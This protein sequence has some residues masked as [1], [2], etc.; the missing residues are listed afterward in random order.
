[1]GDIGISSMGLYSLF[2]SFQQLSSISFILLL[3]LEKYKSTPLSP[4]LRHMRLSSFLVLCAL[5]F[6]GAEVH[7]LTDDTFDSFIAKVPYLWA[8]FLARSAA[9]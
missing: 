4:Q 5:P 9:G 6:L 2:Y 3:N 7:V 1:M 8:P